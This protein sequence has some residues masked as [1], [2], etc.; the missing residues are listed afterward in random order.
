LLTIACLCDTDINRDN[1]CDVVDEEQEHILKFLASRHGDSCKIMVGVV[2]SFFESNDRIERSQALV[3][4]EKENVKS[5]EHRFHEEKS[6]NAIP[7]EEISNEKSSLGKLELTHTVSMKRNPKMPFLMKKFQ[8][9]RVPWESLNLLM[10]NFKRIL[11]T[12]TMALRSSSESLLK[13][14]FPP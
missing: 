9:K 13:G 7:H 4:V 11:S 5:L 3:I 6:K 8:T 10:L 1:G 12:L 2:E 14:H